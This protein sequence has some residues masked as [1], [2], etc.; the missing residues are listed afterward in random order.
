MNLSKQV[1]EGAVTKDLGVL[2]NTIYQSMGDKVP[3]DRKRAPL[4]K[5][6]KGRPRKLWVSQPGLNTQEVT[7]ANYKVS[8][9]APGGGKAAHKQTP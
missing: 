7:E 1:A 3:K 9:Q 2:S 6:Q 8:L 4:Y 5:R